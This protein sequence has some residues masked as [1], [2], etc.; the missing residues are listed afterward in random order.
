MSK[1]ESTTSVDIIDVAGRIIATQSAL[2]SR[3]GVNQME[4]NGL[5]AQ[6]REVSAGIYW[7]RLSI[8]GRAVG[9]RKFLVVR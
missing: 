6:G 1:D 4:W 8:A 2:A 5:D 7:A 9:T 3:P